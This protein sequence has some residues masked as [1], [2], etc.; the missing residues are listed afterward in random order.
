MT[1]SK[2]TTF[3]NTILESYPRITDQA[4]IAT[5]SSIEREP[6]FPESEKQSAYTPSNI[7]LDGYSTSH[8]GLVALMVQ[9]LN[10]KP[11]DRVLDIGTGSGYHAAFLSRL[12]AEVYGVEYLPYA[13]ERSRAAFTELGIS[14]IEVK[15][16][17]GWNGWQ[18]KGPFDL[19]NIACGVDRIPYGL[20]EQLKVGG[21]MILPLAPEGASPYKAHQNLVL[22][23]KLSNGEER[24]AIPVYPRIKCEDLFPVRFMAMTRDTVE[25]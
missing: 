13:V 5:L 19:I 1:P 7:T 18:E 10:V 8:P 25:A 23:E 15:Q 22:I 6:F 4:I 14:N 2:L 11:T 9:L 12:A 21:R 17:D 3:T 16:G 20:I 24:E